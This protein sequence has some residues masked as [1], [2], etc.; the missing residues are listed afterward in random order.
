VTNQLLDCARLAAQRH[1]ECEQTYDRIAAR[2]RSAI[3]DL[4]AAHEGRR[5]RA[6]VD[7]QLG[8]LRAT[9]HGVRRLG[10]CPPAVLDVA[11]SF[12][13]RLSALIVSAYLNRFRRTRFVDAREFLTTDAQFTHANVNFAKTN[14]AARE[15]FSSFWRQSR[16]PVPVV[17]G[18]IAS[19]EDG[20]TTT[21][22]RNGS[23]YTAAII[24]AALGAS[25]I[26]IWTDVDGVLSADP[27]AVSSAFVLPQMT[28]DEAMAMSSLGAKVLHA[29]TIGPAVAKSIPIVIKNT[30]NPAAPGTLI[31]GKPTNGHRL[32]RG[33]SSVGDVTLLTLRGRCTIGVSGTTERLFRAL[34]SHG[35]N[36]L[37]AS[38]ASSERTIC[39]AVNNSQAATAAQAVEQE[40]QLELQ[41]GL[42]T[43]EQKPDQ[44][45]VAVIGDGTQGRPDVAG[46][47][48]GALGRH[49]IDVNAI[50][51]GASECSISCVVNAAER[52]RAL[53][54]LHQGLFE[55]RKSLA[56][57]VV[58]VGNVGGALLR[59]LCERRAHLL[60]QGL[61]ARVIAVADSKRFVIVRD[62]IDPGRWREALDASVRRMDPRTLAQ[63]IA[64]LELAN[65]ALIDCTAAVS[66]VDAYPEF[67]AA[68]L[69]II[70]P[71]KL[72]NV[73]PWRRYSALRELLGAHHRQFLYETNVGAGLPIIS[74]LRDLIASGDVITK[75]EGVFSGTLS[76]LFNTF[77]GTVP[78]ST[79][80]RDA[81]RLG[82]TEPDPR[83]DLTGQDVARKLLILAR[84]TGLKMEFDDV[85]V[86][87][88][89]PGCLTEGP[90]SQQFFSTYAAHD[91]GMGQRLQQARARGAVLRYVGTLE[92]GRARA[93]IREFP[94]DHPFAATKG[95]DNIIAFTTDRYARSPLIVQGPGAGADV[96]A[97]GVL[98]DVFK[99]LHS[100]PQ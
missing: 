82:Y 29:A 87:G 39:V 6:L 67:I 42:T 38:Q 33:I 31:S 91:A 78:F 22:G 41:H 40:F 97:R 100:Q 84:Q 4:L 47:A 74:T 83:Q 60:A 90:F 25:T 37:L 95:S 50:A 11:A 75:V 43:L 36:V 77:D 16:Q 80:V 61:D 59:Q 24:G 58:G 89:V 8:E 64:S 35:V 2:H 63:E 21:V 18:F 72:A 66:I 71:N 92:R 94:R 69:H 14:R 30:F 79:L 85:C 81:H 12:G 20:R 57:V 3:D 73:Q 48:F 9:L 55:T 54:V 28:Y 27:R 7:E 15:Y 62:G 44:A 5:T 93:E 45:I 46:R 52:S 56:L 32:A 26:E 53:N 98:S 65:A 19:T 96:T 23:D 88:L 68:N 49:H 13:E 1:P 34:A 10:Q 17:T 86:D 51:R 70:T 99:L 76:Y